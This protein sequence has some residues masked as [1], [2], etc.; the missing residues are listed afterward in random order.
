MERRILVT[1]ERC[2]PH[3]THS[4]L[5]PSV[6]SRLRL[7]GCGTGGRGFTCTVYPPSRGENIMT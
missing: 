4:R 2:E 3:I 7:T 5:Q 6:L 1:P